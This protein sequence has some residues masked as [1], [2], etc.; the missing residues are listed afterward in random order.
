VSFLLCFDQ[1]RN[2]LKLHEVKS[3]NK[4]NSHLAGNEH[5]LTA[6]L[7]YDANKQRGQWNVANNQK[8]I[9]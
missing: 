9:N 2:H 7:M 6:G 8:L 3:D 4:C 5:S 1:L